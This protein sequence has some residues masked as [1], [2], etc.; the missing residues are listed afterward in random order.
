MTSSYRVVARARPGEANE[1]QAPPPAVPLSTTTCSPVAR[2]GLGVTTR[3]HP[4]APPFFLP[5]S[6]SMVHTLEHRALSPPPCSRYTGLTVQ[7]VDG[8]ID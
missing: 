8:L 5:F 2:G 4:F 1:E 3:E 7:R 6:C